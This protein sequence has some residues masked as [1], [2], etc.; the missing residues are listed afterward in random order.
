VTT[1]KPSKALIIGGGIGGL[2]AALALAQRG[3]EVEVFEQAPAFSEIGA[4]I[5]LGPN[6]YR[7]L[8]ALGVREQAF[9]RAVFPEALTMMDA[10]TGE[11]VKT[12]PTGEAFRA[13]FNAPYAVIHRADLHKALLDK[14]Q[15]SAKIALHT[16]ARVEAFEDQ[17][18]QVWLRTALGQEAIG[19]VL[20]GAD[21][22]WS[23][24]RAAILNDGA[25]RR[26][27]HIAYRAVLARE[28]VPIHLRRQEM[29]L[30][31]GPKCHLVHYPLRNGDLFNL[32]A[33]FHSERYHEG[34]DGNADGEELW[35]RF[36]ET[37]AD[38][39]S[40]LSKINQWRMW[41]LCD[42][43]PVKTWS[44][45]RMTLLGDAAHPMLQYLAQGAGMAMEDALCLGEHLAQPG[46]DVASALLGYQEARYLRTGRVQIT[47][48]LYGE[49]YHAD[50]LRR[51]LRNNFVATGMSPEGLA[52]LYDFDPAP[53]AQRRSA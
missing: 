13:R 10:I 47:A 18:G 7:S 8:D 39:R 23:V 49:F 30:W 45:G 25:P 50:G 38:V 12:I 5:Q 19:E 41:V 32:V 6:S 1:S 48:R 27:G 33:V 2:A 29:T 40:M 22:M 20:I 53:P 3:F 11:T 52:W 42:R 4:G 43:E 36:S 26:S 51:E 37:H 46:S 28:D 16:D 15:A 24:V 9:A 17:G 31:A 35:T 44:S 14:C 34:W 21:G